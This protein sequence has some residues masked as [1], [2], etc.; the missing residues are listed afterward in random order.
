MSGSP[1]SLSRR[2]ERETA[3]ALLYESDMTG[4]PIAEV[5]S[6]RHHDAS[7]YSGRLC[8][9]VG[10]MRPEI[11]ALLDTV[12]KDWP[13][14][15]MAGIDRTIL[16]MGVWELLN[17]PDVPGTAIVSEAVALADMYSADK[18]APFINGILVRV[19][20]DHRTS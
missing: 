2:E 17:A 18:S 14:G 15:R 12:A 7:D 11:D 8:V 5:M 10:E 16:R 4:D 13:V 1:L 19:E 3:L 9:G 20:K 6:R